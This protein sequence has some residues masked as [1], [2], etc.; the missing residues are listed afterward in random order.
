[1]ESSKF[2]RLLSR[3]LISDTRPLILID[4][5]SAGNERLRRRVSVVLCYIF[6]LVRSSALI[7]PFRKQRTAQSS[8]CARHSEYRLLQ[9]EVDPL[10]ICA[11][12]RGLV[13]HSEPFT[14]LYS[15]AYCICS[16]SGSTAGHWHAK[17]AC[18][19]FFK[20]CFRMTDTTLDD[21]LALP[22]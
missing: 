5:D 20:R 2:T 13:C 8:T 3:M 11:C 21:I 17:F 19:L 9:S 6:R 1:M 10:T 22:R 15:S 16:T 12:V 4:S 14:L 18:T 7:I